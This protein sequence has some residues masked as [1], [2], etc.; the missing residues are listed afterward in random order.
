MD[1]NLFGALADSAV[2]IGCGIFMIFLGAGKIAVPGETIKFDQ[3]VKNNGTFLKIAG[4]GLIL[5]GICNF[6]SH[7]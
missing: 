2:E 5:F 1:S 3:W 7:F 6:L 4:P